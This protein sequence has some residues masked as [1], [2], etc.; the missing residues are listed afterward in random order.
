MLKDDRSARDYR[1]HPGD[2][3][4]EK[5]NRNLP[6]PD[7]GFD[8]RL[9]VVT[10]FAR[11]RATGNVHAFARNDALLPRLLAQFFQS[12]FGWR[13]GCHEKNANANSVAMIDAIAV[14]NAEVHADFR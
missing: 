9:T 14:A 7:R 1:G 5:I 13:I 3:P 6:R 10:G 11:N 4:H 2:S 8:D 12:L